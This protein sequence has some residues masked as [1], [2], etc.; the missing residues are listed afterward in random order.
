MI[1]H[2]I[3]DRH[4]GKMISTETVSQTQT[5]FLAVIRSKQALASTGKICNDIRLN[6]GTPVLISIVQKLG[7]ILTGF[8]KPNPVVLWVDELA[9]CI[10]LKRNMADYR[11]I[12][13][14]LCR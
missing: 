9:G 4:V 12:E 13:S 10:Q 6:S 14:Q 3:E 7:Q 11:C 1:I 5:F 2:R 8:F